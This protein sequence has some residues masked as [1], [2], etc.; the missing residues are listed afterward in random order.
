MALRKVVEG[1]ILRQSVGMAAMDEAP[2]G[3]DDSPQLFKVR[4]ETGPLP[5]LFFIGLNDC[6]CSFFRQTCFPDF[7]E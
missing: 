4:I 5:P 3:S 1:R 7:C 2:G 6:G